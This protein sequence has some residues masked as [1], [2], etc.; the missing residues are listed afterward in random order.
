MRQTVCS[1][2]N[3]EHIAKNKSELIA[4]IGTSCRF[5]GGSDSPRKLWE[6]LKHPVDLSKDIP[7][8][9]FNTT[10]FYHEDSEHPG[11]S[12]SAPFCLGGLQGM[13]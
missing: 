4:I 13:S 9:R 2:L 6:L 12:T 10:G 8:S 7:F 11:V 1:T 3:M 5:P